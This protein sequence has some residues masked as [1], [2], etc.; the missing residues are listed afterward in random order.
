[1]PSH[2]PVLVAEG[3]VNA[4][5]KVGLQLI[6][7]FPWINKGEKVQFKSAAFKGGVD[8][9]YEGEVIEVGTARFEAEIGEDADPGEYDATVILPGGIQ[10][11]QRVVVDQAT[12]NDPLVATLTRVDQQGMHDFR[13]EFVSRNTSV[14]EATLDLPP[15]TPDSWFGLVGEPGTGIAHNRVVVDPS[16]QPGLYAANVRLTF[17]GGHQ[18]VIQGKVQ[19][20]ASDGPVE[21]STPWVIH[22]PIDPKKLGSRRVAEHTIGFGDDHE[23]SNTRYGVNVEFVVTGHNGQKPDLNEDAI[24]AL[25][26]LRPITINRHADRV[27][28]TSGNPEFLR[29]NSNYKIKYVVSIVP[30][31]ES[32][33]EGA[34]A[35]SDSAPDV[36]A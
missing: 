5:Q 6:N 7:L 12:P 25:R 33:A 22:H 36:T 4:G 17:W 1:M 16:N 27:V 15:N 30:T 26:D 23:Q 32:A 24:F 9:P 3:Y 31:K 34:G 18:E 29:G 35:E 28:I 21:G 13:V 2:P 20:P 19:L 11:T 8:Q 10:L 14:M